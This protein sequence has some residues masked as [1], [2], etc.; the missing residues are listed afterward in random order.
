MCRAF[1]GVEGGWGVEIGRGKREGREDGM[2]GKGNE[3][4]TENEIEKRGKRG[5]K[6]RSLP[7]K[8]GVRNE[9]RLEVPYLVA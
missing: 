2:G 6:L 4:E 1:W 8:H 5:R 9:P 3:K 7:Q